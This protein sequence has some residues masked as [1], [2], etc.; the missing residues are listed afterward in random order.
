MVT[1]QEALRNEASRLA[2]RVLRDASAR[3]NLVERTVRRVPAGG[4]V[5]DIADGV[6]DTAERIAC[7]LGDNDPNPG[8][9]LGGVPGQ[10]GQCD[11]VRYFLTITTKTPTGSPSTQTFNGFWGPILGIRIAPVE[12][13]ISRVLVDC[14]GRSN[15]GPSAEVFPFQLAST[16]GTPYSEATIDN[17]QPQDN[18]VD[19]CGIAD[20][21]PRYNGPLTY[22]EGDTEV[23][24]NVEIILD[25]S[26]NNG[27]SLT[28][29]LIYLDPSLELRPELELDIEPEL[30][31]GRGNG[32]DVDIELG[33]DNTSDNPDAPE[34]F[35]QEGDIVGAVVVS[36]KVS[37]FQT[38]TELGDGLPPTLYL[39]RCATLLFGLRVGNNRAWT[40]PQDCSVLVQYLDVPGDIPA[41]TFKVLPTLGFECEVFPVRKQPPVDTEP[42]VS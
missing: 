14:K 25:E 29:P 31:F 18:F 17:I 5:A 1:F 26:V 42:E 16:S 22:N 35:G 24:Q 7:S 27:P 8:D 36:T 4:V 9:Q 41:Y 2:C 34:D 11:S 37:Q 6:F 33:D 19:N 12:N 3:D 39:P 15:N 20:T 21:R 10:P 23:T 30:S 38:T 13:G 32:C 28:I 40:Q